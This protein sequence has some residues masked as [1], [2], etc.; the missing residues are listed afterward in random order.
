MTSA[1]RRLATAGALVA[2]SW[3]ALRVPATAAVEA[4]VSGA[5]RR[6]RRPSLDPV[7]GVATDLGSV[8][9]LA[10][11]SLALAAT[12]R[13]D[14]ALDVLTAGSVA[15]VAAQS[16]K[17]LANRPRPYEQ[18]LAERL[19]AVP[20]GSSWPSGHAAVAAAIGAALSRPERPS[21]RVLGAGLAGFVATSRIYVGVHHPTDVIAGAGVGLASHEVARLGVG[22]VR[23][24]LRRR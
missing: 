10:G 14:V 21:S 16:A 13:R 20:A 19:V 2:G 22:V 3:L 8:Y 9:G 18:E 4:T 5:V 7:V 15:W 12:G 1:R 23:R 6:L 24:R 11:T 17:P